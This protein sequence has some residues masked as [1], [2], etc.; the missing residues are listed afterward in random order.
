MLLLA[1]ENA[2]FAVVRALREAGHDVVAVSQ[3]SPRAN[4]RDIIDRCHR[5]IRILITEDKDFGQLV[6]ASG[7]PAAGVILHPFRLGDVSEG[8]AHVTDPRR[9]IVLTG[10]LGDGVG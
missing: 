9:K 6:Y 4:D 8:V 1:D 7:V 3:L 10:Q 2:D 5:E